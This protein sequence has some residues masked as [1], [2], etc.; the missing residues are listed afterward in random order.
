MGMKKGGK[1]E[2]L[3]SH[4][5]GEGLKGIS[6]LPEETSMSKI[7]EVRRGKMRLKQRKRKRLKREYHL[8]ERGSFYVSGVLKQKIRA[9]GVKIKKNMM[10]EVNSSNRTTCLEPIKS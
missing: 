8:E 6:K 2:E 10:R 4:S 7:E 1:I 9:G 3:K 5:G